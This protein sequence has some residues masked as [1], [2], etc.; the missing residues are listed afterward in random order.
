MKAG[1]SWWWLWLALL[2]GMPGMAQ[3]TA[4]GERLV[5]E[6]LVLGPVSL[7]SAEAT[8]L[9]TAPAVRDHPFLDPGLPT[10]PAG[11]RVSWPGGEILTWRRSVARFSPTGKPAVFFLVLPVNAEGALE[12]KLRFAPG[13]SL[14]AFWDGEFLGS[15]EG[16]EEWNCSLK[17]RPGRHRLWIQGVL[18]AQGTAGGPAVSWENLS[19]GD[20]AFFPPENRPLALEDVLDMVNVTEVSLSPDQRMVAVTLSRRKRPGDPGSS[21]WLEIRRLNDGRLLFSTPGPVDH[22]RWLPD[23][24][25]FSFAR[26][27]GGTTS[28]FSQEIEG[29]KVK[30]LASGFQRLENTWWE[31]QGRFVVVAEQ[32][33]RGKTPDFKGVYTLEN[34]PDQGSPPVKLTAVDPLSAARR[35]LS[36]VADNFRRLWFAPDGSR[37]LLARSD[38][39]PAQRPYE[40]TTFVLWD[41][42]RWRGETLLSSVFVNDAVWSPGGEQLVFIGG[43]SAFSAIGTTTREGVVANEGDG[44]AFLY[45]LATRKASPLTRDFNPSVEQVFWPAGRGLLLKVTDRSYTRLYRHQPGDNRFTRLQ[46]PVD[47]VAALDNR[48]SDVA[49][50]VGSSPNLPPKVYS[51]NLKNGQTRVVFDY[52][53]DLFAGVRWGRVEEWNTLL[54]KDRRVDGLLYLP[55]DFDSAKRLPLIVHYYGGISPVGRDFAGRYPKEWYAARGYAVFVPQPLGCVG[56]GQESSA[57]HVNDWGLRSSQDVIAATRALLAAKPFLDPKRV[58]AIGASYG[59]FLTQYLACQTD[60]FA[61]YVSHAGISSLASYWGGGDWGYTYSGLAT[62]GSF[63]WNRKD[64][65]VGQSPLFMADRINQPIL[66]THGQ[67]DNNVPPLESRQMVTALKL[68]GKETALLTFPGQSHFILDRP[69]ASAWMRAI[70][71][72]FDRW[73][74]GE[75]REWTAEFGGTEDNGPRA[76]N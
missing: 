36:S 34:Q 40:R 13:F 59:G 50:F 15:T 24:R 6:W 29:G 55:P 62:A 43:P 51:L 7:S 72:W 68:L 61:A 66:F 27:E 19:P 54:E 48:G 57:I 67:Q 60:L 73:L 76:V 37:L 30:L 33:P 32:A 58:G 18:P 11:A 41:V 70:L 22:F 28:L 16:K 69:Q 26:E 1:K 17:V 74:K 20:V 5:S 10:V 35:P 14:R 63:P 49:V 39:D 21:R 65:Y 38:I 45:D 23:S 25:S 53:Q 44:Q 4:A 47:A 8:L 12:A 71:A 31:P 52:N 42:S 9:P 56:Y 3:G 2:G 46:L 64:I 75:P